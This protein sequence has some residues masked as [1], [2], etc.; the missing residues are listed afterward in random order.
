MTKRGDT[1]RLKNVVQRILAAKETSDLCQPGAP[2]ASSAH[3]GINAFTD[4]SAAKEKTVHTELKI[5]SPSLRWQRSHLP[6]SGSRSNSETGLPASVI[7]RDS[8]V[9]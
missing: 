9:E 4:V 2:F 3:A 6:A 1:I 7:V 8:S 5:P